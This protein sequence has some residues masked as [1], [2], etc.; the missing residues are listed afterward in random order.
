MS[1]GFSSKLLFFLMIKWDEWSKTM[2][3]HGCCNGGC[4]ISLLMLV[5]SRIRHSLYEWRSQKK[6]D[7]LNNILKMMMCLPESLCRCVLFSSWRCRVWLQKLQVPKTSGPIYMGCCSVD[8][9]PSMKEWMDWVPRHKF[10]TK[11]KI[12]VGQGH[13]M[14]QHVR[15]NWPRIEFNWSLGTSYFVH[16]KFTQCN[17]LQIFQLVW[18]GRL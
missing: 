13:L 18:S 12:Y 1:H 4:C 16:C 2:E 9:A 8:K 3:I 17:D 7:M 11:V 6:L 15:T 5:C 14:T 10:Q